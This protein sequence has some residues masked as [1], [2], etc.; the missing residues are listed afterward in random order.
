M[1]LD[2]HVWAWKTIFCCI[3]IAKPWWWES[4]ANGS[5]ETCG[6]QSGVAWWLCTWK[7]FRL[8][9]HLQWNSRA[10]ELEMSVWLCVGSEMSRRIRSDGRATCQCWD[11]LNRRFWVIWSVLLFSAF[12]LATSNRRRRL[13]LRWNHTNHISLETSATSAYTYIFELSYFYF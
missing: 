11:K 2:N 7:S 12:E 5:W 13:A 6:E 8:K 4:S 1:G 3:I 9:F 10:R